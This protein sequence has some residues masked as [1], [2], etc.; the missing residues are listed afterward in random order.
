ME[1]P[2]WDAQLRLSPPYREEYNLEEIKKQNPRVAAV[3]IMLYENEEGDIEFPVILRQEY[4][5]VHS[6][7]I[8]LPGGSYESEDLNLSETAIRETVEELGVEEENLEVLIQLS[9]LYIP[10]SDFLV[11]PFVGIH[12]GVPDFFRQE[13]EVAEIIPLDLEAFL[14]ADP[15]KFEKQFGEYLVDI[16]GYELGENTYIWGAT[17]MILSEFGQL[18]EKF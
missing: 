12:H 14:A 6:N 11:Y 4:N 2:G 15:V 16:P 13:E 1:L 17:A 8:S 3:M 10:P 18:I 7:Q 9:E 5:G